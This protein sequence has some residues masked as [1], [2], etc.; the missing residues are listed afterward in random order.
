LR[1]PAGPHFPPSSPALASSSSSS[2]SLSSL[3]DGDSSSST[4]APTSRAVDEL[5]TITSSS[6]GKGQGNDC[7]EL[8]SIAGGEA[9]CAYL[10]AH[11]PCAA[12]G[13]VDYLRLFYCGLAGAPSVPGRHAARCRPR[14][15]A[16]LLLDADDDDAVPSLPSHAKAEAAGTAASRG[17]AL[18]HCLALA[19][20]L[21]AVTWTSQRHNPVSSNHRHSV[22][23]LVGGAIQGL[24]LAALAAATS[25]ATSPPRG[26]KRRVPWLA[27][28][29]LM[30]VLWV[31][32][33][34]REL[35]ALLVSIGYVAGITPIVLGVMVLAWGD[36]LGDLVSNVVMAVHVGPGGVLFNTVVGLS[37]SLALAAGARHPAPFV[38]PADAAAYEAVGFLGAALAWALFVVPVRGMRIDR[39]YGAGLVAIST[40]ASSP[41]ASSRHWGS[42]AR[43]ERT[44]LHVAARSD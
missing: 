25:N 26:R 15:A 39:V 32:T 27:A 21:L 8:Q 2:S 12:A 40:S 35:M 20:L 18:L 3:L 37:L 6:S 44:S 14:R 38:V 24:I 17:R 1:S 4:S 7:T 19:P 33:L 5:R 10:R 9:R 28:G 30:S 22:A 13:Y 31:Y 29:F 41:C 11:S 16:P 43:G 42:G 34:A 23:V 36:S